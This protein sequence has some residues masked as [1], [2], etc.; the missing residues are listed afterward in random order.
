MEVRSIETIVRALNA[1]KA[2]YPIVGGLAV[3]AH[4]CDRLTVFVYEPFDFKKEFDRAKWEPVARG[5]RAPVVDYKTLLAMKR[6][7]G[8]DKGLL[9]IKALKKLD[10]LPITKKELRELCRTP[11]WRWATSEGAEL[12]TLL[13]ELFGTFHEKLEWQEEAEPLSLKMHTSRERESHPPKSVGKKCHERSGHQ[14]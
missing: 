2:E 1:A 4:G 7:A 13:L 11:D 10:P 8:R 9:D 3:S 14:N 12:H 5:V 6:R